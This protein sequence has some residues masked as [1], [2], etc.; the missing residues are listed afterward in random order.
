MKNRIS[1]LGLVLLSCISLT[2]CGGDG[3]GVGMSS[4]SSD[5][6]SN[7]AVYGYGDL[8]DSSYSD[9]LSL[10]SYSESYE[11]VDF[12]VS[13]KAEKSYASSTQSVNA[14]SNKSVSN[15]SSKK[16]SS[17]KLIRTVSMRVG[18][19]SSENL[20]NTVNDIITMASNLNGWVAYN[21]VDYASRYAG[22]RLELRIPKEKVDE[23][24]KTVE[25]SDMRIKSKSDNSQDVTMKYVDTESRL[26][27]KITQRDKYMQYLEQATNTTELLEIEDRLAEVISDIESYQSQLKEMDSLIEYTEVSLEIECET[28]ANRESFWERFKSAVVD[29]RENVADTLLW[30]LDWFLNALIVLV[31]VIPIIIIVIRAI[32]LAFTGEWRW[33]KRNKTDRTDS[34]TW[35]KKIRT[36]I[37]KATL[38]GEEKKEIVKEDKKDESES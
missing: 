13:S 25:D 29:I 33:K 22:G 18:I 34:E 37:N 32:V 7:A 36:L 14:S 3:V 15:E 17:Q 5:N 6:S 10:N 2:A 26:N 35:L 9:S 28:S 23:F 38:K 30:G 8:G 16:S 21:N 31:F 1:I 24:I 11:D 19:G 4:M 12:S 27:V 20:E